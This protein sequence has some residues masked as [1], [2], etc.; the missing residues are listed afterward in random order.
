MNFHNVVTK[1]KYQLTKTIK[2]TWLFLGLNGFINLLKS[3]YSSGM[4]LLALAQKDSANNIKF[5]F[6]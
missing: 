6:F 4:W 2:K 3:K 5:Q 1:W